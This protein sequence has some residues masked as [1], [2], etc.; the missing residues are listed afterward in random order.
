MGP[1]RE[2]D[3]ERERKRDM[4]TCACVCLTVRGLGWAEF[5]FLCV[6]S[7]LRDKKEMLKSMLQ[8][9]IKDQPEA[10]QLDFH[11]YISTKM[12]EVSGIKGQETKQ[13]ATETEE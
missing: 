10:A 9:F 5:F 6:P 13:T 11:N 1:E 2:K 4:S 7:F 3:K 8:N 12:T